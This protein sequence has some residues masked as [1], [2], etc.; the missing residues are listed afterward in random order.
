MQVP[1]WQIEEEKSRDKVLEKSENPDFWN[2]ET[3][4]F[5][6][7]KEDANPYHHNSDLNE[8]ANAV[9]KER[10]IGQAITLNVNRCF[11]IIHLKE[12]PEIVSKVLSPFEV[13]IEERHVIVQETFD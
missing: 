7:H 5:E 9:I 13:Q 8:L 11:Q 12:R 3:D 2:Y 6:N 10:D 1:N 4:S